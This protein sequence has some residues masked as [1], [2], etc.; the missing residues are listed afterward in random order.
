[1]KPWEV[2]RFS[3]GCK[4]GSLLLK[5]GRSAAFADPDKT[6]IEARHVWLPE[7]QKSTLLGLS[8]SSDAPGSVFFPAL[9]SLEHLLVEASGRQN[10]VLRSNR[11]SLQFPVEGDDLA[12]GPVRMSFLVHGFG[13]MSHAANQLT[14]LRRIVSATAQATTALRWAPAAQKL[15]DAFITLDGRAAQASYREIALVLYGHDYVE[16]N[17]ETGLKERMRR[18]L[19]RSLEF[20]QGRYRELLR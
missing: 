3:R 9:P 18:H 15:R 7:A 12:A 10:V 8:R 14:T 1:V 13:T 4:R 16:R 11:T 17:W 5:R 20:T 2:E 19:R 6:A